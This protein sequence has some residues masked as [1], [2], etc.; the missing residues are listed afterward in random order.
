MGK[1]RV[2]IGFGMMGTSEI[3]WD[4]IFLVLVL[5]S[6]GASVFWIRVIAIAIATGRTDTPYDFGRGRPGHFGMENLE[7]SFRPK[8]LVIIDT[9][10]MLTTLVI[11]LPAPALFP[12]RLVRSPHVS[13]VIP[14]SRIGWLS[15][16]SFNAQ[17]VK[18]G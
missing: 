12:G 11:L 4:G 6:V 17:S 7:F 13:H 9:Q 1:G 10:T 3:I 14:L 5:F 2:E 18:A 8:T 16:S 15:R